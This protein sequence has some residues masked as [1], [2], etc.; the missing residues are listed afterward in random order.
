M[1]ANLVLVPAAY[2]MAPGADSSSGRAL[3][4]R[5]LQ[6]CGTWQGGVHLVGRML[7]HRMHGRHSGYWVARRDGCCQMHCLFVINEEQTK[8]HLGG[9]RV[10]EE[11]GYF[12]S[13]FLPVQGRD[14]EGKER[15]YKVMKH[16]LSIA[17]GLS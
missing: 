13:G 17:V 1:P 8:A 10:Q 11:A 12:H 6:Q 14:W 7:L 9:D 15:V 2:I 16:V 5:Q 4:P 3:S